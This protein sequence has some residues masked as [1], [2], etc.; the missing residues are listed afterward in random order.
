MSAPIGLESDVLDPVAHA[1]SGKVLMPKEE[2]VFTFGALA[3]PLNDL[4]IE[5]GAPSQ[6]D[7]L[8]LDVEGAELEVLRG[9]NHEQF[10]FNFMCIETRSL[11]ALQNFCASHGY[12]LIGKISDLDYLF[13]DSKQVS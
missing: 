7:F 3:R 1:Q 8:S 4:L 6:I 9:V 13:A 2:D 12:Y 11:D 5:A 10:R